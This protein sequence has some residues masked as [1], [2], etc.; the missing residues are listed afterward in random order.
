MLEREF[1]YYKENLPALYEK[2]PNRYVVL[3]GEDVK[4]DGA[5]FKETIDLAIKN[6]LKLGTFLV[7]LC[8]KD[9]SCYTHTFTRPI[10]A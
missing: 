6:D 2:Y 5:T 10:F 4:F 1:E 3:Q 9:E 7:Q 8:G